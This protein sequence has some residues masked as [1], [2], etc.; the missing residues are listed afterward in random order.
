VAE[1]AMGADAFAAAEVDHGVVAAMVAAGPALGE[2]VVGGVGG[3]DSE[4]SEGT[5]GL[6]SDQASA[7]A[8]VAAGVAEPVQGEASSVQDEATV[9]DTAN[10]GVVLPTMITNLGQVLSSVRRVNEGELKGHGSVL[11]VLKLV[12]H[13]DNVR[14]AW[15][16]LQYVVPKFQFSG[17]GQRK[18]PVANTRDMIQVVSKLGGASAL[19][20]HNLFRT[21]TLL[22]TEEAAFECALR[23]HRPSK[24]VKSGHVYAVTSDIFDAIKIGM[25][26]GSLKKLRARYVGMYGPTVTVIAFEATSDARAAELACMSMLVGS[27]ISNELYDK[28]KRETIVQC[29]ERCA[30]ELSGV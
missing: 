19:Q 21:F 7:D 14:E 9:A 10:D 4:G 1:A 16:N 17:Q 29:L 23:S 24:K 18:T 22:D 5:S 20:F 2:L 27:H 25:W 28:S 13:Q 3:D 12:L 8:A 30:R 6:A 11:D 15:K 26:S